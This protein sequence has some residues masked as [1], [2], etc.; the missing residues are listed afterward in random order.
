MADKGLRNTCF[1]AVFTDISNEGYGVCRAPDG[2]TLF[3]AG[4]LP[5]EEACVKI[6]KEY[7]TYLIGRVEQLTLPSPARIESGCS[8]YPR[9]GGC[10]FRHVSY[11][12]ELAYK[13]RFVA[14]A[15]KRNAGM[16]IAVQP[17]L[18]GADGEYRNK[19][20]LPVTEQDGKLR[21]GFY[22]THSHTVIPCDSCRLHTPDFG[23]ICTS[24]LGRLAGLSAYNESTG[25]GLIR[26]LYLRR[27]R[28]GEFGVCVIVNGK[29]LPRAKEI[30]LGLAEEY[31]QV[32]S[33]YVNVNTAR[34]NT[35]TGAE[36]QH[37]HGTET[38]T[39]TICGKR[40]TLSPASFFQ[41]N[42]EMTDVLYITAARLADIQAGDTVFDMY[43]GAGTVGLCLCP[44]DA[45]L[46]G[47]E[48]VPQAVENAALNAAANGRSKENTRF[49]CG[50]AAKGFAECKAAFGKAPDVVL[51]DPP[52]AGLAPDLI[53]QIAVSAPKKVVYISCN[54]STLARDLA[55]FAEKGYCANT[56]HTVDMFPRTTHV[57]SVVSL[58]RT[59]SAI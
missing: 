44:E 7:K 27:T 40:F 20:L 37:I 25:K 48:I 33:F 5:D 39:D 22:A 57:E 19:L 18:H 47:V 53:E 52:R 12:T 31:P 11:E 54:P 36:W 41:V 51:V 43:C 55:R 32:K 17:P 42:A 16:D 6:I 38:L 23:D 14:D 24:L 30:A 4:A 26:H 56:V 15:F 45:Y 8:A 10:A 2:R 50:D 34:T 49:I 46:C 29:A 35:V 1:N 13:Q 3:A 28:L 58:T 59:D 21:C 9:C